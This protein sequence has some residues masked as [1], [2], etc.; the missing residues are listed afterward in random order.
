MQQ[1]AN[2]KQKIASAVVMHFEIKMQPAYVI[3]IVGVSEGKK[4]CD[5]LKFG[6]HLH[7]IVVKKTTEIKLCSLSTS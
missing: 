7:D 2:K 1:W 4:E 3:N 5:K 6:I